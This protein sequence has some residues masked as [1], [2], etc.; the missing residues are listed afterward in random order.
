MPIAD[1]FGQR[2]VRAIALERHA[3]AG[4]SSGERHGIGELE[5][6]GVISWAE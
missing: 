3:V 1:L 5:L 6:G 4:S 2:G